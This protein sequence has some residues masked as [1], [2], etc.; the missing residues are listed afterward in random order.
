MSCLSISQAAAAAHDLSRG[1][2][3]RRD[4]LTTPFS[5]LLRAASELCMVLV[6]AGRAQ[7]WKR[8]KTEMRKLAI[9]CPA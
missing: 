6:H 5:Y 3:H 2:Y 8:L 4:S 7:S 1:E 9:D